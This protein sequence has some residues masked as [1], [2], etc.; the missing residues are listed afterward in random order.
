MH[1]KFRSEN[2]KGRDHVEDDVRI[3]LRETGWE[4]VDLLHLARVRDQWRVLVNMVM[5]FRVP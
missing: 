4:D 2:Q 3:E 1:T 5:N